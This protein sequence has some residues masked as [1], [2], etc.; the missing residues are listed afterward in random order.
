MEHVLSEKHYRNV[1]PITVFSKPRIFQLCRAKRWLT[2]QHFDV[3][4]GYCR[5]QEAAIKSGKRI[6]E[7]KLALQQYPLLAMWN[8]PYTSQMPSSA[9]P[10]KA[11]SPFREGV[12]REAGQLV[13]SPENGRP[14]ETEREEPTGNQ[15]RSVFLVWDVGQQ[16]E[17]HSRAHSV[18]AAPRLCET[19]PP[20]HPPFNCSRRPPSR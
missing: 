11:D 7:Q 20:P 16:H 4:D 17:Q 5:K 3:L 14:P 1:T 10:P 19:A 12:R 9:H 15:E 8:S 13:Q 6:T 2:L 18:E